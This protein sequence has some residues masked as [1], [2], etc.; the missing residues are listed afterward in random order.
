MI[1]HAH[2]LLLSF[3]SFKA[4]QREKERVREIEGR[5]KDLFYIFDSF[6]IASVITFA[7]K[8]KRKAKAEAIFMIRTFTHIHTE[9]KMII[10]RENFSSTPLFLLLLP[11]RKKMA[12]EFFPPPG[13][14]YFF[15]SFFLHSVSF[16]ICFRHFP[17]L[18]RSRFILKA[19][20]N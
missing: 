20:E 15:S 10:Y 2:A 12:M 6:L 16:I 14:K 13:L 19:L 8:K 18:S 3:P 9:E 1:F 5:M 17:S 4:K 11:W 7:T